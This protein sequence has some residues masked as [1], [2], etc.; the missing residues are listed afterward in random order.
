M[1]NGV[2][3]GRPCVCVCVSL[4]VSQSPGR[5]V[6]I[7]FIWASEQANITALYDPLRG[8]T[9]A[10]GAAPTRTSPAKRSATSSSPETKSSATANTGRMLALSL[11][12]QNI[13]IPNQY[14][15]SDHLPLGVVLCFPPRQA[16]AEG[17]AGE[18]GR[19]S[20]SS[21]QLTM[22]LEGGCASA[23]TLSLPSLANG[24]SASTGGA[25][26]T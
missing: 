10:P 12:G 17:E 9:P 14:C 15:P 5:A 1:H 6:T 19:V 20:G 3:M 13:G 25:A 23:S 7:D 4:C 24:G 11:K 22:G 8:N 18:G 16:V 21:G 2:C 26:Q